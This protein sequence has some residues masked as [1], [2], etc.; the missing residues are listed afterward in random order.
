MKKL[1]PIFATLFLLLS[2]AEN[3]TITW[4]PAGDKIMTE[5]GE[6]I[7][8]NNVLPEYPRPQLVRGE[9]INLNGLWD[10]AIKPANEEMP[11][12]FD[13]KILVPFA[14]ESALSGVGKSVGEDDALWYSREFKLPK[15]WKNSRIRLNFGA[16][17]W[18]AEVYVDDK[19][20]GEH[21]G[22][23]A[24]F[25]FDITD[26]LSKKKTHKLVVK[27]TDA[28]DSAFQPR[29]KQ[30]ANPNGIWYTAVTG[31]WQTV[32]MEPVNE[33]VVE[34]YSAKAD[35]EKSILNVRAIARG[36][37]VGDDCLIEL[38][39]NGEVISSANGADVI[40]NVENPK[41]WS[42]DS[43][44]LYDLRITI[45]RNGEILDQV[46]GYA[47]MREISVVVDKKGYKRMALNGEPLF[48][49][50]TLD[51]GW[52]PDGLYT[53]PTD[54][55]LKFDI[56]KTKE[57]GF[58]M[59]RKHVKVEPARWYWHC[60]RIGMLVWQDMPNIHDNS[61]GKW[62]RRHYDEGIDTPVPNEWKDNYCRE[63]KEIIQT[64]EVFP[65]IVMWV[66]F[67][68][69]W[70]QFNTEEI[71]QYT[72][73]LDDSRL[74][75]YASGGNFVRCS[76]DVLDL[77]N[78]PNPAMYLFD[79]DYV[80]VMGEYGGIGF[81]VEGHLWQ[82]D[83]NWGYIQYKS[84]DEVADTYEEYA[85]ELIGFVKKGFSGAIYT[86]TTDVEGEVNGLM[87]Y[88]RK[89]IKL[90]VDRINA[91]NSKVIASMTE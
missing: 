71:V 62:G 24:P 82:T 57:F 91:I 9:W 50:G 39:E 20:V 15:E 28:T 89:V 34:S 43:P 55:A 6:N 33:V 66:P 47:A 35:I 46:M 1:L 17:D 81:P 87:T 63:W 4:K 76:G 18:K 13:G 8:P 58:N 29:G 73:F 37:K 16:V 78:Y 22:G 77:H 52:W 83:K 7:D 48:Q 2:C 60:D 88:D 23:Y 40:L 65:S 11:E 36:A 85:N 38:I 25:A 30:V 84:A 45:Y 74:V 64:N 79:K 72:K 54:E 3:E 26:S 19:F 86:Q 27:V 42:P 51:Q 49:Y 14:V 90:D 10:Y 5:W 67:N 12:I 70:G 56:E 32:W 31:I 21:K 61:L 75:N 69:A 44:Y 41:L 80:N 59:I 53:A 68:E